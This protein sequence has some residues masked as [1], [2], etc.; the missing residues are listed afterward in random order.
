M[1]ILSCFQ[2]R[3]N[4]P[5]QEPK[6]C[7]KFAKI[8]LVELS[9]LS[10]PQ[11]SS[12][13]LRPRKLTPSKICIILHIIQK[14]KPIIHNCFY[15]YQIKTQ[16]YFQPQNM[17]TVVICLSQLSSIRNHMKGRLFYR[18]FFSSKLLSSVKWHFVHSCYVLEAS[19]RLFSLCIYYK[20][21]KSST[22]FSSSELP[23]QLSHCAI[24]PFLTC[25]CV[26][27]TCAMSYSGY[28]YLGFFVSQSLGRW[29]VNFQACAV[30]VLS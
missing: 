26:H 5:T 17:L 12:P 28:R 24:C 6:A 27:C 2:V 30:N 18:F 16:A 8:P 14:L 19:V 23:K 3:P 1:S 25:E 29:V 7:S 9:M 13:H 15:S 21:A 22:L 20:H 4:F 10:S 11:L